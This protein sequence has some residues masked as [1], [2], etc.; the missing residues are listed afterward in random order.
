M[1][2]FE[3]GA[4]ARADR[5]KLP[6]HVMHTDPAIVPAAYDGLMTLFFKRV[7]MRSYATGILLSVGFFLAIL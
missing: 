7:M 6:R 4:G 2:D 1:W 3:F 5:T